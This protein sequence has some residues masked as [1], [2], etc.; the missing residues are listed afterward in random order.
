VLVKVSRLL[1]TPWA[2]H[3]KKQINLNKRSIKFAGIVCS[4]D[5][6]QQ[7]YKALGIEVEPT[8]VRK[9]MMAKIDF[10]VHVGKE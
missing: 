7:K 5:L 4:S 1:C 3:R 2:I 6:Y 8:S 10:N 9:K